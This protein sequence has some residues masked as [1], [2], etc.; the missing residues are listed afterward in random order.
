MMLRDIKLAKKAK[1]M[2]RIR[3]RKPIDWKR[4]FQEQTSDKEDT[5]LVY[6]YRRWKR[7]QHRLDEAAKTKLP[8]DVD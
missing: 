8:E 7:V 1:P 5:N 3:E 6:N 4:R 2:G